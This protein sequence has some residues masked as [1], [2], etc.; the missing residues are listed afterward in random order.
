MAG[1]AG[2][3]PFLIFLA[4]VLV[5]RKAD[6]SGLPRFALVQAGIIGLIFGLLYVLKAA[7]ISGGYVTQVL[8]FIV[9]LIVTTILMKARK[10]SPSDIG[11]T[12]LRGGHLLSVLCLAAAMVPFSSARSSYGRKIRFTGIS[13]IFVW[14]GSRRSSF[15]EAILRR[16]SGRVSPGYGVSFPRS[17][18]PHFNSSL[19]RN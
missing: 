1:P 11:F 10:R 4:D 5:W 19:L 14:S 17:R 18:S 6:G 2:W 7:G 13:D 8:P 12:F 16:N 9:I 3:G 15:S